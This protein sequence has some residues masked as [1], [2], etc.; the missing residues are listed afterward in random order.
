MSRA[1]F[2]TNDAA[3]LRPPARVAWLAAALAL[4]LFFRPPPTPAS[5]GA[6]AAPH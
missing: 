4:A 2:L 5:G 3:R 6:V 1:A